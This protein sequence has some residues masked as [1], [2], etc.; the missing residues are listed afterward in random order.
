[1]SQFHYRKHPYY[2][3][4]RFVF[5]M[6]SQIGLACAF[7]LRSVMLDRFAF[8]VTS[9]A[10]VRSPSSFSTLIELTSDTDRPK[11][12]HDVLP[13]LQNHRDLHNIHLLFIDHF[14]P[15]LRSNPLHP[16]PHFL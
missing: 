9:L 7:M 12:A 11:M 8:R 5:V 16:P 15:P 6:F 14:Y 1:M 13:S 4:G 10:S 2:L 3:N